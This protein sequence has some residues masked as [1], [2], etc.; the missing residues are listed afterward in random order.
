MGSFGLEEGREFVERKRAASP[1]PSPSP[2]P[3][4]SASAAGESTDYP[5]A[6]LTNF[7]YHYDEKTFKV[8]RKNLQGKTRVEVGTIIVLDGTG[9]SDLVGAI[10]KDNSCWRVTGCTVGDWQDM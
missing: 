5:A 8:Y 7:S 6:D 9:G 10:F 1:S 4:G 2:E 3:N